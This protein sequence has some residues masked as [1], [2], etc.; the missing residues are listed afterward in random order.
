MDFLS[1][2][3]SLPWHPLTAGIEEQCLPTQA[4]GAGLGLQ[5]ALLALDTPESQEVLSSHSEE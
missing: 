2:L 5:A 3:P 1:A 4:T